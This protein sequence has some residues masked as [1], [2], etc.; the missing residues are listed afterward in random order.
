MWRMSRGPAWVWVSVCGFWYV[1]ICVDI[2]HRILYDL[3]IKKVHGTAEDHDIFLTKIDTT[4]Q[5]INLYFI[6]IILTAASYSYKSITVQET[7]SIQSKT[8]RGQGLGSFYAKHCIL[9]AQRKSGSL[10]K[11][12]FFFVC[13]FFG[14][15]C[16]KKYSSAIFGFLFTYQPSTA[17]I[18]Q[19]IAHCSLI[20]LIML[21]RCKR[22]N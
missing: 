22:S 3:S 7:Y 11:N 13:L 12:C 21:H 14:F 17:R 18:N 16:N 1:H 5:Q 2:T 8:D 19:Q 20:K 4:H 10:H 9:S 6:S 15:I